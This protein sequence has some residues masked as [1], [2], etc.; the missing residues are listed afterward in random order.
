MSDPADR[1][2]HDSGINEWLA[3]AT[4]KQE[5]PPEDGREQAVPYSRS[6]LMDQTGH[7]HN[8]CRLTALHWPGLPISLM[9]QPGAE[10]GHEM[11][12]MPDRRWPILAQIAVPPAQHFRWAEASGRCQVTA[13]N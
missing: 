13:G 5:T 10:A 6:N 7:S 4:S 11:Q 12:T 2:L 8:R 3:D 9:T 1:H